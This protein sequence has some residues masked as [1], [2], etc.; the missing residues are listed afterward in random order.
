MM[1]FMFAGTDEAPGDYFY[2]NG[3]RLKRY[4]G[5]ASIEAMQAGGE[6]RY[7]TQADD[8]KV[9]VA[10]GVSGAVVD[11]GSMQDLVP[12]LVQALRQSLQDMGM[13]SVEA[14]QRSL[15]DESLR[16]ER[17]SVAAQIEGGVHGLHSYKEP[18]IGFRAP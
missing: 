4:R 5:M 11:K 1:G 13:K 16:F 12:Y 6:K 17:R 18:S 8:R 15:A 10:Q 9:K 2:E 3:L 14:L 7:M